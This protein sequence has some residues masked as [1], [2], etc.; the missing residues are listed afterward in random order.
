MFSACEMK[1]IA[2]VIIPYIIDLAGLPTPERPLSSPH[3]H[4]LKH[5]TVDAADT[6]L[7]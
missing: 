4:S 1:N 5:R 3:I 7:F 6:V 2:S